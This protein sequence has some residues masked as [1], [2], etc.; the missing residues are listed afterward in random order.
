MR[1]TPAVAALIAAVI[2][3]IPLGQPSLAQDTSPS[4]E[5]D[6]RTSPDR[7]R[8]GVIPVGQEIDVR[9]QDNL[10]SD[11]ARAE[12]RF[13]ATTMVDLRKDGEVLVPAGSVVRGIVS[14]A[15]AAG[16]LN[17]T[18]RLT[19]AFD[20]LTLD[21]RDVRIRATAT[22][23]FQSDGLEGEAGRIGAGAGV[24]GIIGGILGG[25]KGAL[26]GVLIGAGGT[27]AA[28][29]GKELELP[30]GTVVRVRFDAPVD[31]H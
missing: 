23:V 18:G 4:L 12:D 13:E 10:R 11:T 17:R 27:V 22:Q 8:P 14:G 1:E 9:L 28:T 5:R 2:L 26:A 15:Q 19:L 7:D 3:S 25:F 24:G 30:R 6:R 29:E 16:R 21:G 20:R 31:V